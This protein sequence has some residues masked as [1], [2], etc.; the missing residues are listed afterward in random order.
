MTGRLSSWLKTAFGRLYFRADS[1]DSRRRSSDEQR[2]GEVRRPVHIAAV[3]EW[4]DAQN[5]LVKTPVVIED[6]SVFGYRIHLRESL[7]TGRTVWISSEDI[8]GTKAVV[9][10]CRPNGDGFVA[11]LYQI[12]SE[13]RRD[14]RLPMHD[15]ADLAWESGGTRSRSTVIVL[16]SSADGVQVE[17][18]QALPEETIVKLSFGAWQRFGVTCYCVPKVEKFLVGIHFTGPAH[19]KNAL[20]LRD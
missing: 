14:D 12:K 2:S 18:E 5:Q 17:V 19:H 9:R 7:P 11:G 6:E 10:H 8:P 13:R 1:R 4:V 16:D 3:I 15:T 20:E